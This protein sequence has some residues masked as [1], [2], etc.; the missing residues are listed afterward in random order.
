LF[1]QGVLTTLPPFINGAAY[2]ALVPKTDADGNDVAGIRLPD[3]AA[4]LATYTGWGLRAFHGD[5]QDGCDAAGQMIPFALTKAQ[6]V[7]ADDPRLSV[8]ERYSNRATYVNSITQA[9]NSLQDQR[10]LLNEDVQRY[11]VAAGKSTIFAPAVNGIAFSG[12][13]VAAGQS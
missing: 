5:G 10:L 13:I 6:R 2:P 12:D 4:P 11:I 3:L 1:D 9:A 8:E 7:A